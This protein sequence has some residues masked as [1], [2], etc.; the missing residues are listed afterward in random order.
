MTI[1]T[2]ACTAV[3]LCSVCASPVFAQDETLERSRSHAESLSSAFNSAAESVGESVVFIQRR[4]LITPVRRDFFGRVIERGQPTYQDSGLG[5]GVIVSADGYILTNNHVIANAE[6]VEVQLTDGRE[7]LA[8]V[9]GADPSTDIAVLRVD[10]PSL[11][12]ATFGDSDE[13]RVG[14]W[15]LAVGSPFG[16]SNTVTAGIVSAV[17][18]QGVLRNQMSGADDNRVMYEEFIQTDAAINP[19]NSGGPL[20]NLDGEIVGI[21]TA[22]YS[23]SGGGS[24]GLSFAIPSSIAQRVFESIRESGTVERGWLGITM[25]DLTPEDR[26]MFEDAEGVYVSSVMPGSPAEE[27]GL[28]EGDVIVSFNG[29]DTFTTN[30]LRNSIALYGTG[31]PAK[32]AYIRDGRRYETTTTL[33]DY[34]TYERDMLGVRTLPGG[35]AVIELR[36]EINAYLNLPE[37]SEGLVVY[38]VEKGSLAQ[39][40]GLQRDD[41]ITRAGGRPVDECDDLERL[42]ER[43]GSEGVRLEIMRGKRVGRTTLYTGNRRR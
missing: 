27:S 13:L 37:R 8:E 34:Q 14:D 26:L 25:A 20:V 15:V 39:R 6:Q 24:I 35:L 36:P 21:N 11:S 12:P 4:D 10:A 41:V 2:M 5:S 40:A 31:R 30:R 28:K 3:T 32:L 16:L 42:L 38:G 23:K 18:R 9:I 33:V 22:I 43:D 19:G 1:R 7:Y 29:R 17:G